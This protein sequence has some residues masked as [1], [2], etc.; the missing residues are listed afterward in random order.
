MLSNT[1]SMLMACLALTTPTKA[2]DKEH[3][4]MQCPGDDSKQ[5][6]R[7]GKNLRSVVRKVKS[8]HTLSCPYVNEDLSTG[9]RFCESATAKFM[10]S[11][12]WNMVI[13]T[14][15]GAITD[16]SSTIYEYGHPSFAGSTFD[17]SVMKVTM[18][19]F[20]TLQEFG[21]VNSWMK[22]TI[23]FPTRMRFDNLFNHMSF[24]TIPLLGH[25]KEYF[26]ALW[27]SEAFFHTSQLTAAFLRVLGIAEHR[28]VVERP[29]HANKVVLPWTPRWDPWKS[30]PR[31]GVSQNLLAEFRAA[32]LSQGDQRNDETSKGSKVALKRSKAVKVVYFSRGKSQQ[33]HVTN[34]EELL[35]S[36]RRR[37]ADSVEL[38][39]IPAKSVLQPQRE[40]DLVQGWRSMALLL[41][42]AVLV[43]GPHGG[44][45][46]QSINECIQESI[47]CHF[48]D[49][50]VMDVRVGALNNMIFAPPGTHVLEFNII[51]EAYDAMS[52][53]NH[54][55]S[56]SL[57]A[58]SAVTAAVERYYRPVFWSAAHAQGLTY[59]CVSPFDGAT[60]RCGLRCSHFRRGTIS[61]FLSVCWQI[62]FFIIHLHRYKFL[63]RG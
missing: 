47:C 26:P 42:D 57:T 16:S 4:F 45:T 10:C 1:I 36:I 49:V 29:L 40:V 58:R 7:L 30:A 28:I 2:K 8:N 54:E 24:Q 31:K 46:N 13:L 15:E 63:Q 61:R 35:S 56:R 37:L 27:Q 23:V 43:M 6:V 48:C 32:L 34:E 18:K 51:P 20:N 53:I 19:D 14:S 25:M 50:F 62:C 59:W 3:I 39:V 11:M 21:S 5:A 41:H 9:S 12:M 44:K 17:T 22:R 60:S 33:R 52:S 55:S 38:H